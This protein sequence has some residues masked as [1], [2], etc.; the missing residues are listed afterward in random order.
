MRLLAP[1][2]AVLLLYTGAVAAQVLAP[3]YPG[4]FKPSFEEDK[5]WEEQQA[6]LPPYPKPER[7]VK[8][9]IGRPGTFDFLVDPDSITLGKD[10]AVRYTLVARSASGAMNVSFE[11]IRC[12]PR[13]RKIYAI[14]HSDGTWVQARKPEWIPILDTEAQTQYVVLPN[15]IFCFSGSPRSAEDAVYALTHGGSP[16][17]RAVQLRNQPR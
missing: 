16:Q 10:K 2:S 14:G 9:D 5:P 12:N 11:G 17:E 7:L 15:E 8:I 1:V 13:E 4:G 3:Q 6:A